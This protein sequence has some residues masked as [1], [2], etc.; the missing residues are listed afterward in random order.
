M[1]ERNWECIIGQ[2]AN[3]SQGERGGWIHMNILNFPF[4]SY[5]FRDIIQIWNRVEFSF[6]PFY[7]NRVGL[8][9][10]KILNRTLK[11]LFGL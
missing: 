11:L 10:F 3:K 1:S 2:N 6:N 9:V 5:Y 8:K 7:L 4:P